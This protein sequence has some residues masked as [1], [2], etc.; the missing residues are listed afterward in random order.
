MTSLT[1]DRNN[2]I[3]SI[4]CD[5]KSAD[6]EIFSNKTRELLIMAG[7][8]FLSIIT[9]SEKVQQFKNAIVTLQGDSIEEILKKFLT[10]LVLYF[11][12]DRLLFAGFE[13][14]DTGDETFMLS[15]LGEKVNPQIHK[16]PFENLRLPEDGDVQFSF[17]QSGS[18]DLTFCLKSD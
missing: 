2:L 6:N 17:T 3:C 18:M 13:F 9:Q 10:E 12:E 11:N 16:I 15:M 8:G 1:A 7:K 4:S 5:S 14:I